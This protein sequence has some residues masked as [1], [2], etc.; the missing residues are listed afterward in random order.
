MNKEKFRAGKFTRPTDYVPAPQLAGILFD[1]GE[2][3]RFKVRG[4]DANEM[5]LANQRRD[6]N[7][8][9]KAMIKALQDSGQLKEGLA[10]AFRAVLG[11]PKVTTAAQTAYSTELIVMGTID[12][13]GTPVLDYEDVARLGE[14]FPLVY[15]QLFNR[16]KELSGEASVLSG[17]VSG[18]S[19]TMTVSGVPST[20]AKPEDNSSSKP[21]PTSSL[22]NGLPILS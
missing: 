18:R 1:A 3:A 12:E 16:I 10:E 6:E 14:H 2:P 8:P 20:S 21:S 5:F 15:L 7:N 19:G 13:A 11:D 17:E 22:T 4:L 9:V